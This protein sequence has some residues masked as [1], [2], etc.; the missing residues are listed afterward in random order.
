MKETFL[1]GHFSNKHVKTAM[2]RAEAPNTCDLG[3]EPYVSLLST[4]GFLGRSQTRSGALFI[5]RIAVST[6][7]D[8]MW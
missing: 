2:H 8:L 7:W 6:P 5:V 4:C 1:I 3:V